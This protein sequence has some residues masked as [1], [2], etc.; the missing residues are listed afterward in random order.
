LSIGAHYDLA[1]FANQLVLY[2]IRTDCKI[3][4]LARGAILSGGGGFFGKGVGVEFGGGD[5]AEEGVFLPR[6]TV[7]E[8]VG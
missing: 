3:A 4:V 5:D 7:E 2:A 1:I 6:G 8:F